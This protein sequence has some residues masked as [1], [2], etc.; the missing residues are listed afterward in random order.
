MELREIA[1]SLLGLMLFFGLPLAFMAW[2]GFTYEE[3]KIEW[4]C[5]GPNGQTLRFMQHDSPDAAGGVDS[6]GWRW[7]YHDIKHCR[8]RARNGT[9]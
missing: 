2:L 5:S 4:V 7:A 6:E 3:R 8:G 9:A 1:G